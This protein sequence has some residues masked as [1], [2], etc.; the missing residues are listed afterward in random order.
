MKNETAKFGFGNLLLQLG[1]SRVVDYT[2]V[3]YNGRLSL[4]TPKPRPLPRYRNLLKPFAGTIWLLVG[5]SA[6]SV[7]LAVVCMKKWTSDFRFDESKFAVAVFGSLLGERKL[8][9][10]AKQYFPVNSD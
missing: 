4:L 2:A 10:N 7:P 3:T 6:I 8:N 1:R 9:D 5:L